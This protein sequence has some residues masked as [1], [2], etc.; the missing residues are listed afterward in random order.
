MSDKRKLERLEKTQERLIT[1]VSN[2]LNY[3]SDK[4]GDDYAKIREWYE[5]VD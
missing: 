1:T 2:I 3:L 4:H 5:P